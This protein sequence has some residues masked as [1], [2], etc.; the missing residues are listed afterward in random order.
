MPDGPLSALTSAGASVENI[1][2]ATFVVKRT[3]MTR[4][5][6]VAYAGET[7]AT[8]ELHILQIGPVVFAGVE[9]EPFF[10]TGRRIKAASPFTPTWF[11]GYTGG[12]AGYIPTTEERAR[13]GYEVDISP[14][15]AD[16]AA[17]LEDA[18]LA[19]LGSLARE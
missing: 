7:T 12:W 17:V 11:G 16:A 3:T 8:V 9:G 2:T 13:K 15:A 10:A 19:A 6:S 1:E 14:F 4:S 5:R 18:V